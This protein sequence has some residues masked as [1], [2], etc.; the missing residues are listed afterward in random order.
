MA[1]SKLDELRIAQITMA[2]L[3]PKTRLPIFFK[4]LMIVILANALLA[5][6][7]IAI[8]LRKEMESIPSGLSNGNFSDTLLSTGNVKQFY[9]PAIY[10]TFVYAGLLFIIFALFGEL[11]IVSRKKKNFLFFLFLASFSIFFTLGF[12]VLDLILYLFLKTEC[13]KTL[14]SFCNIST[15]LLEILILLFAILGFSIVISISSCCSYRELE[16]ESEES[17]FEVNIMEGPL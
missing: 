11:A 13:S 8:G 16:K 9:T 12:G 6:S 5:V 15:P 1:K 4:L 17:F 10:G 2:I 7:I 14:E 3:R